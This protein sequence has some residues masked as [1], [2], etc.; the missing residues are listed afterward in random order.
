LLKLKIFLK[1][2]RDKYKAPL[3]SSGI[4]LSMKTKRN[5]KAYKQYIAEAKT[6]A[7]ETL[8]AERGMYYFL[9]KTAEVFN[10]EFKGFEF[11]IGEKQFTFQTWRQKNL[12]SKQS[13][14]NN[15]IEEIQDEKME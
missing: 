5:L 2:Q 7:Q 9:D 3:E 8:R 11:S 10:D 12:K 14:P 4:G 1:Q 15:F 13:D 6:N